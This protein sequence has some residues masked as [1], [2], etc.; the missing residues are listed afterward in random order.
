MTERLC[1]CQVLQ[2]LSPFLS[3][4]K[5]FYTRHQALLQTTTLESETWGELHRRAAGPGTEQLM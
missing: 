4:N 3:P 5:S 1:E 2:L